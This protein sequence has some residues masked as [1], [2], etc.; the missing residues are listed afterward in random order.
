MR[1]GPLLAHE[2]ALMAKHIRSR[3]VHWVWHSIHESNVVSSIAA[4]PHALVTGFKCII[5]C[6]ASHVVQSKTC[7]CLL[8]FVT[9]CLR[10]SSAMCMRDSK[11]PSRPK[12]L[13]HI[14]AF[15]YR[16]QMAAQPERCLYK[17]SVTLELA[18]SVG[19]PKVC[20]P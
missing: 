4:Q 9:M 12:L 3:C 1:S 8:L 18:I 14:S 13:V 10:I 2:C 6:S 16:P 15:A 7:A 5:V 11:T 17:L 19:S 20:F